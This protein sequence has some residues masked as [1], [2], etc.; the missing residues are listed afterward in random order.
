MDASLR[1]P[2]DRKLSKQLIQVLNRVAALLDRVPVGFAFDG[3]EAGV[4][5]LLQR[6]QQF[7][8]VDA[9]TP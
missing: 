9:A 1:I 4:V 2:T 8:P 3:D 5:V 6:A 7:G